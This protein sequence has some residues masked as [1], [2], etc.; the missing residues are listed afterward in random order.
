M[1]TFQAIV[2]SIFYGFSTFLPISEAAH[3]WFIPYLLGWPAIEGPLLGALALGA[4]LAA[5]FYF[6]HDWASILSSALRVLLLWKKPSALDERMLAFVLIT[7]LPSA[8]MAYYFLDEIHAF[9][10][11]PFFIAGSLILFSIPLKL[12]ESMNR[13]TKNL[14]AWN[15][16][17]ALIVGFTQ[18]LLFV[19]GAGRQTGA[20]TG[21]MF[22]NYNLEA[23][24]KFVFFTI[25]PILGV[26]SYTS[27]NSLSFSQPAPAEGLTWLSFYS[28]LSVSFFSSLLAIG[29]FMKGIHRLKLNG[30]LTYRI[31]LGLGVFIVVW[32]REKTN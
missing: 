3:R 1:N 10:S 8:V 11:Q 5:L 31:V 4:F 9:S 14:F 23:T 28:A 17:D 19:P 32:L 7:S 25:V 18:L 27:L 20:L 21:A 15:W 2:V 29:G 26:Q 16:L 22:R 6:R 12:A 13:K 30:Y 24:A